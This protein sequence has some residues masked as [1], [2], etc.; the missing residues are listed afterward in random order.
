MC[1]PE[2]RWS[3]HCSRNSHLAPEF[4]LAMGIKDK[5]G[6]TVA[7]KNTNTFRTR[8]T[9][10]PLNHSPRCMALT[11]ILIYSLGQPGTGRFRYIISL[12]GDL[13]CHSCKNKNK[14]T[15][16]LQA[17]L[18]RG[19]S[20]SN[21]LPGGHKSQLQVCTTTICSWVFNRCQR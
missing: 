13:L 18:F 5:A 17:I 16:T 1:S 12:S 15:S 9:R 19:P 8:H 11:I 14:S 20:A 3:L 2:H 4:I 10:Q 21:D 7:M 6:K